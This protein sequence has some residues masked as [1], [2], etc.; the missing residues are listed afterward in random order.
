MDT[1]FS[2]KRGVK[3]LQKQGSCGSDNWV[4]LVTGS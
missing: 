3:N 1:V 2:E 4:G